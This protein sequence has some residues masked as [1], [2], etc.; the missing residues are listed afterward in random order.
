[1]KAK[2]HLAV[3]MGG[4]S[5]EHDVSL[6]SGAEIIKALD[7]QKYAVTKIVIGRDGRWA[8]NGKRSV[9]VGQGIEWLQRHQIAVA[10]IL[11]LHGEFGED[12]RMQALLEL[13]GIRYTGSGVLASAL[14]MDKVRSAELFRA[15]GLL[16][17]PFIAFSKEEWE[18]RKKDFLTRVRKE[19]GFPCVVKPVHLGSSVGVSIVKRAQDLAPAIS[20]AFR[21]DHEV[22]VQKYILGIEV[23]CGV[24][25]N[26]NDIPQPLPP[27][28]IVPKGGTFFD[29]RAKYV[30][31]ASDEITP[32]RISSLLTR[33]VQE[34]ALTAHRALGCRGISRTD[35][36]VW[37]QG[38]SDKRQGRIWVLEINTLPGM[39]T[40]SLV[41]Q[42]AR[43]AGMSFP[44]LLDLIIKRAVV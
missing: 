6:R 29:Y 44:Q 20:R 33:E 22:M 5:V 12:G 14:G 17:P 2:L 28:E 31:G 15:H 41:L 27:T 25:E 21:G 38:K 26:A 43:A 30:P 9:G 11:A 7:S 4:P 36:I 19:M 35:M 42:A 3:F 18:K 39:T 32:A 13:A 40:T 34:A 23:T 16:V 37:R 8:I 10:V 1:M 24:I